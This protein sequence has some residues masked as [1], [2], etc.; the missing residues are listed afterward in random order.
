MKDLGWP[1]LLPAVD[2]LEAWTRQQ[3]RAA[4]GPLRQVLFADQR[5]APP[6]TL[7]C[8]LTVPLK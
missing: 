1:V 5:T 8:D 6:D 2:A 4:A 7:V 3:G